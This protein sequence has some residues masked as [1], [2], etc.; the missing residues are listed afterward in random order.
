M[1]CEDSEWIERLSGRISKSEVM[2]YAQSLHNDEAGIG[3]LC[4]LVCGTS[5]RR[6]AMNGAWILSHLAESDNVT[7]MPKYR[8]MLMNF[9][10]K[11]GIA[12][13]RGL[14]ITILLNIPEMENPRT[15]YLDYCMDGFL[16]SKHSDSSRAA[17][18]KAAAR[19]CKMFPELL[20]ELLYRLSLLPQGLPPSI[21]CVRRKIIS[22]CDGEKNVF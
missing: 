19:I 17:M 7:Y 18:I 4:T 15:D 3:E 11:D 2:R 16:S 9:A 10:M 20:A 21:E 6:V 12:V 22:Q 5:H 8:D 14:I 1:S 13:R